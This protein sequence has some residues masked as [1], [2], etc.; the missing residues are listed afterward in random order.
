[1]N[2]LTYALETV[3]EET[4]EGLAAAF[5]RSRGYRTREV[6]VAEALGGWNARVEMRVRS[7]IAHA[8]IAEDWRRQLRED[9]ATLKE[10]E[11]ERDERYHLFVFV[12]NQDVTGQQEFDMEDEIAE[13][14]GWRLRLYHRQDLL[15]E[16][17]NH[18]PGLAK[19]HLDVNLGFDTDHRADLEE[20]LES[21]LD[22]IQERRDEATDLDPGPMVALHVVPN[23]IFSTR[24][25]RSTAGIP[26]PV[27]LADSGSAAVD[28]R[29]KLKVAYD[30]DGEF[31][32][33][34]YAL[35]RNDGLYESA[36]TRL[37]YESERGD[38]LLRSCV[39]GEGPGLDAA[40][41]VAVRN[42][43]AHLSRMG[44]SA[45]ASVWVSVLDASGTKLD[46]G[47]VEQAATSSPALGVDRYSTEPVTASI[48]DRAFEAVV[49]DLE[50]ALSELWRQFGHPAGTDNVEDGE[51]VGER[52]V[53]D[54]TLP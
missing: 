35:L 5:L 10:I 41:V 30:F 19:H 2:E 40:V 18:V 48:D 16:I 26:D 31:G 33:R 54:R 25:T 28:A 3:D 12:T 53:E 13:E 36:T 17:Y 14:Y 1:M 11:E 37:F 23:G 21:R 27:V 49:R 38:L 9:A 51:W 47:R 44:Y 8:S 15:G 4:F 32:S 50:P 24:K 34:G 42:A 43:L 52:A 45:T 46:C 20:L 39:E 7:G 29:G 6:G 22:A